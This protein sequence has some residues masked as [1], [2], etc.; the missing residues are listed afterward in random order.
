MKLKDAIFYGFT[1]EDLEEIR[2]IKGTSENEITFSDSQDIADIVG[3]DVATLIVP[4]GQIVFI[5]GAKE[6]E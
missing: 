5:K 2:K 1:D 3:F 4:G 6:V